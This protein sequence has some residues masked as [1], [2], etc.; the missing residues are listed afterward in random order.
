[1]KF[2]QWRFGGP[3]SFYY[4]LS[5]SASSFSFLFLPRFLPFDVDSSG[6]LDDGNQTQ[7]ND[8]IYVPPRGTTQQSNGKV[9][10]YEPDTVK[11][12]G[13]VPTL[14]PDEIYE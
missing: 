9:Q 5:S 11:Y 10:C 1:M 3:C 4:W 6:V 2:F 12:L 7:E 8:F 13:Y 14:T